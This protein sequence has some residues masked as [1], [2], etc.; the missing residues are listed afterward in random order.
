MGCAIWKRLRVDG[1]LMLGV[2]ECGGGLKYG[3]L[4]QGREWSSTGNPR[5]IW[6]HREVGEGGVRTA[7][8]ILQEK[9]G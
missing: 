5:R 1:T 9:M 8:Q 3:M 4:A 2:S 6:V 7:D